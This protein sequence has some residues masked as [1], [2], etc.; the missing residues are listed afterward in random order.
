MGTLRR[1]NIWANFGYGSGRIAVPDESAPDWVDYNTWLGPAPDRPYNQNRY[2][3]S[4]RMFWDYGGGLM[5]D[6]GVHLIDMALWAKDV[7]GFPKSVMASGGIFAHQ[8]RALEMADTQ[9]VIYEM[10]DFLI[11]WEHNG[12]VQVGPYD[13]LYGLEYKGTNGTLVID[14]SRW[15]V[16]PEWDGEKEDWKIEAP[17]DYKTD[18]MSHRMHVQNFIECVKSREKPAAD[19]EIGWRVGIFAHLGNIAYRTGK[20]VV[21]DEA[22]GKILDEEANALVTPDYR[23][24]YSLPKY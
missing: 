21:F 17:E 22:S 23:A 13:Q 4:W 7:N 9:N 1:V 12:G 16:L 24:P 15:K 11:T 5:T 2:H 3:G 18:E 19:I 8:D 10:D 6:W 20:K 14:R